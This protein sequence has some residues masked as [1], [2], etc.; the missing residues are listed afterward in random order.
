MGNEAICEDLLPAVEYKVGVMSK[1]DNQ[2][3]VF[4]NVNIAT[5]APKP[6]AVSINEIEADSAKVSIK[7]P[8]GGTVENY[9]VKVKSVNDYTDSEVLPPME[10]YEYV[11][12]STAPNTVITELTPGTKYE[13]EIF[14]KYFFYLKT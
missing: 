3:S 12:P 9:L 10:S 14:G 11:V 13:I 6:T 1:Y 4:V 7:P 5:K 2:E 8:V